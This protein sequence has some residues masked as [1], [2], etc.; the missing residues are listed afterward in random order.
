MNDVF[1]TDILAWDGKSAD[2]LRTAYTTHITPTF[3][4]N[5]LSLLDQPDL[6]G[7]ATWLLKHH[8]EQKN[9]LTTAQSSTLISHFPQIKVWTAKLHI[10]QIFHHI[11]V[12]NT[13]VDTAETF[14]R[15]CL[16]SKKTFVRAW[17]YSAFH[18]LAKQHPAFRS[19]V[20]MLL[21]IAMDTEKP[22]VKARMR[23][24]K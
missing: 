15:H 19:E 13:Q 1:V 18:E 4:D 14:I 20:D 22:S 5:L 17:A 6:H 9:S 21:S 10:L 23:N 3:I 12:S 2:H 24:L 7:G 16:A 8:L 11:T